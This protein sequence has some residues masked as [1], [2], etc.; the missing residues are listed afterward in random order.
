MKKTKY[1]V[2]L[3]IRYLLLIIFGL[4]LQVFYLVFTPLTLILLEKTLSLFFEIYLAGNTIYS[5]KTIQ[6]I[7]ACI[8][9]SAYYLLLILNL[10]TPKIKLKKRILS[11]LFMFILFFIFNFLRLFFLISLELNGFN[12]YFYHK[13]LW[14]FGSTIFVFLIWILNIK[15]FKV[16]EIPVV[17]DIKQI[18]KLTK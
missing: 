1:F 7:P 10:T 17:S 9:G 12:T 6:I 13:I 16:K 18:I 14:Y 15:V 11:I 2:D 4:M 5:S 3:S 8:G